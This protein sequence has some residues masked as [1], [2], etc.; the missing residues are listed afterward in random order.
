VSDFILA[1]RR[2]GN[3]LCGRYRLRGY[4]WRLWRWFEA[5][6]R[7]RCWGGWTRETSEEENTVRLVVVALCAYAIE[8]FA[9]GAEIEDEIEVVGRLWRDDGFRM[10]SASTMW[11]KYLKVVV[12]G[13]YVGTRA[14][15]P[16]E[17]GDFVADLR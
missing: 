2:V 14:R 5:D 13:D 16:L 11:R 15:Y 10:R 3:D 9:S 17:D 6:L 12:E 7:H 4:I 1:G 8:Q